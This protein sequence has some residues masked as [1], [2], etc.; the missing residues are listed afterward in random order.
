MALALPLVA[1]LVLGI[2]QVVVVVRDQIAVE[3]AAREAAR[4]A[5][6]A[7]APA[8][9]ADQA[10]RRAT[11]LAPLTVATWVV[12]EHVR[13]DVSYRDHTDVALIGRVIGD[14]TVR[15]SIT[16]RREPP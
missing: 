6:V 3:L 16:M 15:A 1:M 14:V 4:A 10:A 9:A 11:T 2:V 13:V 5:S 12:G 8:A 7:A